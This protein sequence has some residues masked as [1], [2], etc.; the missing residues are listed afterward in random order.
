MKKF[1]N[2]ERNSFKHA[3]NG[4]RLLLSERH[5][6]VHLILASIAIII[7]FIQQ[8]SKG[9]WLIIIMCI[10]MV[11]VAEAVNTAIEKTVD[12]ISEE[13]NPKAK[14]IKDISAGMVLLTAATSIIIGTLVFCF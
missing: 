4:I 5:F 12:Y 13:I 8:I 2:S 14:S 10:T 9:D 1:I 6:I 11:I 7:G 3:F